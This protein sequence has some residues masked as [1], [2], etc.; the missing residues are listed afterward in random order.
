MVISI[1][2]GSKVFLGKYDFLRKVYEF[3]AIYLNLAK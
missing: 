2:N 1:K 3:A